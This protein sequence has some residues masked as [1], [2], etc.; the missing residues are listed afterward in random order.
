[1]AL[2]Q[3]Y[4]IKYPFTSNN[5]DNVF[6]DT[7]KTYADSVRSKVM[8]VV[9]TQKGQKLRDPEFGTNLVNFLFG[10]FDGVSL[11]AIK[12]EVGRQISKYVPNVIFNDFDVYRD[13]NDDNNMILSLTYSVQNGNNT[14]ATTVAVKLT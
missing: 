8:H 9:L 3:K 5:E 11:S 10:A 4:G 2:T 1:M 12:E 13:E 7:N 14:E 6:L